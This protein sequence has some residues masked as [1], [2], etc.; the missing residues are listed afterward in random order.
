MTKGGLRQRGVGAVSSL[1]PR[2]EVSGPVQ[3]SLTAASWSSCRAR[4]G[5]TGMVW[6]RWFLTHLGKS[7]AGRLSCYAV[8]SKKRKEQPAERSIGSR[9]PVWLSQSQSQAQVQG[10]AT[11]RRIGKSRGLVVVVVLARV[12]DSLL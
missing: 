8:H 6:G 11:I 4:D 12:W 3:G 7:I 10:C 9:E 2:F 1:V 5:Q